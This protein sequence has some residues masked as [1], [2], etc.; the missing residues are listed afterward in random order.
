MKRTLDTPSLID[1][2]KGDL[3]VTASSYNSAH[4]QID[5]YKPLGAEHITPGPQDFGKKGLWPL[6]TKFDDTVDF[7]NVVKGTYLPGSHKNG[8]AGDDEV[9]MP[10]N[11]VQLF[12]AASENFSFHGGGGNDTIHGRNL[13]DFLW[14]DEGNDILFGG[15][16]TDQLTG[17]VGNDQLYGGNGNDSIDGDEG[18]DVL[19]GGAGNDAMEGGQN[20]DSLWGESGD[21]YLMGNEGDDTISGAAG[22]DFLLGDQGNDTLMGGDGYDDLRGY[23]GADTLLG[24]DG[25]DRLD[26]GA[27]T[28][29]LTGGKGADCFVF[30]TD[31]LSTNLLASDVIEDF[32]DGTDKIRVFSI[33]D[34]D[35]EFG[36]LKIENVGQD[37]VISVAA[38][39]QYVCIVK[40]AAGLISQDDLY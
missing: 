11:E 39:Q 8:L 9:F 21:D 37:C 24:G 33:L 38:T 23:E 22:N 36:D 12:E 20:D 30:E 2:R 10:S 16:A 18:R 5:T 29:S 3:L 31:Y 7:D 19:F 6:F 27:D 17:G 35:L 25:Y 32:E 13:Q 15:D 1:E 4:R 40:N 28:D 34:G 14:G 26:G